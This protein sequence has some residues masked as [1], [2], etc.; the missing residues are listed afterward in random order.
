[1]VAL[2]LIG[3]MVAWIPLLIQLVTYGISKLIFQHSDKSELYSICLVINAILC[4][5]LAFW[6]YTSDDDDFLPG[7]IG[8]GAFIGFGITISIMAICHSS[9]NAPNTENSCTPTDNAEMTDDEENESEWYK[10]LISDGSGD[11]RNKN[12][13]NK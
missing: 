13:N 9:K 11:F 1:M 7:L 10:F 6:M 12:D 8:L 5:M 4:F 3:V 2:L